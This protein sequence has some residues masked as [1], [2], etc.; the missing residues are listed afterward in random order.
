[1]KDKVLYLFTASFPFSRGETFLETEIKYLSE[2][3]EKIYII[4]LFSYETE[5]V[6]SVPI[7]CKVFNPIIRNRWQHYFIGLFGIKTLQVYIPEFFRCGIFKRKN[8]G[9]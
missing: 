7:N 1:M 9:G 6:R 2:V 4:P 8:W 3:F 5:S